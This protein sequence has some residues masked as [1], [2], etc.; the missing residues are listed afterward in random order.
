MFDSGRWGYV[1]VLLG[2]TLIS[3][4]KLSTQLDMD[5]IIWYPPAVHCCWHLAELLSAQDS[6]VLIDHDKLLLKRELQSGFIPL[7][8]VVCSSPSLL[9][10]WGSVDY[11]QFQTLQ[12][13]FQTYL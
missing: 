2:L 3:K 12:K 5:D 11:I 10:L 1:C 9:T 7:D 4:D 8:A 6:G 13:N